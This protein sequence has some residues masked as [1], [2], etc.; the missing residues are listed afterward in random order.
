MSIITMFGSSVEIV[1]DEEL[2][3]VGGVAYLAEED[4][5]MITEELYKELSLYEL[6]CII[7]H[8]VGHKTLKHTVEVMSD[9]TV[10]INA[11]AD[12]DLFAIKTTKVDVESYIAVVKKIIKRF[13]ERI[14]GADSDFLKIM[15]QDSE[16]R[17]NLVRGLCV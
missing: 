12:A 16:P 15:L 14:Y 17:F 7:A 3:M 13:L 1:S 10:W 5:I 9:K 8:E 2:E 6:E 4:K 11:E